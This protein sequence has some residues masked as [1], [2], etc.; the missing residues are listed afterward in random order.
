VVLKH[1]NANSHSE[2]NID[3]KKNDSTIVPSGSGGAK[4]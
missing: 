3:S 1:Y 4:T 2:I